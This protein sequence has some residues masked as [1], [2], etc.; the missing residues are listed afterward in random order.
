MLAALVIVPGFNVHR[1]ELEVRRFEMENT[2]L[3][4]YFLKLEASYNIGSFLTKSE[5]ISA[6]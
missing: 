4:D 2:F 1:Y 5:L 6:F 3:D